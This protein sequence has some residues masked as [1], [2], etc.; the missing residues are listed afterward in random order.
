[1]RK[2]HLVLAI[3]V[4]IGAMLACNLPANSPSQPDPNAILT[5]AALTVQAQLSANNTPTLSPAGTAATS[6]P[7]ASTPTFTPIPLSTSTSVPVVTATTSCDRALFITDVSYPDN[8]TVPAGSAFT[9]TWRLQNTG[10]CSWTPSYD[11]VF[12]SDN[13]MNGPTVQ[14][15]SGNVNPGQ[16]IDISVNLT[17]PSSNG[18]YTG[19]WGLRNPS[20]VIFTHFYVQIKVNGGGG[21]GPF[22]V[23]SVSFTTS[24]G[25]GSFSATANI[26]VN[27]AGTVTGY[28]Q[29]NDAS[30]PYNFS[31]LVYSSAGTQTTNITW[32]TTAVGTHSIYIYI[33]SPNHQQFGSVSFS[34]P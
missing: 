32:A 30:L 3:L 14:A 11:V 4:I 31:S 18:T 1:M 13:M 20:G 10:S 26:T 34:C 7:S 17:A 16:T 23:T 9:K 19:Y 12:I 2:N 27:N 15:L 33:N 24:G 28:W 5:A 21:S 25:C 6:A 22:A 8:T 29:R